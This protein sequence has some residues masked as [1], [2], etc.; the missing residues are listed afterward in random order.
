MFYYSILYIKII[1]YLLPIIIN[2]NNNINGI[3]TNH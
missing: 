2:N 1:Y 3:T